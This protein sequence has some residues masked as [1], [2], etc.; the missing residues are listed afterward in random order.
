MSFM[1]LGTDVYKHC[2]S[3]PWC[4]IVTGRGRKSKPSLHPI[5]VQR[6]AKMMQYLM[7]NGIVSHYQHGFVPKKSFF[8]NLLESSDT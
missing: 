3:C 1:V 2:R 5:P 6:G 4:A 8:T 7:D